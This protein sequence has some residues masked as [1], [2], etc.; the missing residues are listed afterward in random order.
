MSAFTFIFTYYFSVNNVSCLVLKFLLF[1]LGPG[2]GL[3][4]LGTFLM[5]G[6]QCW[7]AIVHIEV[8]NDITDSS[9]HGLSWTD[10][11]LC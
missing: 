10:E 3:S 8:L 9:L 1:I 4:T 6:K 7:V 11:E 5:L 2:V